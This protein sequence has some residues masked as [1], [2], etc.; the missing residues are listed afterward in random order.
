MA[1]GYKKFYKI[2]GLSGVFETKTE[3]NKTYYTV[4]TTGFTTAFHDKYN[5][6]IDENTLLFITANKNDVGKYI[7]VIAKYKNKSTDSQYEIK[8][9]KDYCLASGDTMLWI[10]GDM[11]CI[12]KSLV[13]TKISYDNTTRSLNIIYSNGTTSIIT[14]ETISFTGISPIEINEK[15]QITVKGFSF[16]NNNFVENN[17]MQISSGASTTIANAHVE[18]VGNY[19]TADYQHIQGRWAE[20][21]DDNIFIIGNGT[22]ISNKKTIFAVGFSGDMTASGDVRALNGTYKLSDIHSVIDDDWFYYNTDEEQN[23][24]DDLNFDE[25]YN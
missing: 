8:D 23:S 1:D 5:G 7:K 15:N 11:Y 13:V 22:D 9:T 14:P 6:I 16:E 10:K 24:F 2:N 12:A 20:Q 3:N 18:G 4:S 19:A 21:N 25:A 17:E